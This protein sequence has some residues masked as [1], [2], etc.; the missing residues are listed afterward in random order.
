[1]KEE[2]NE[3]YI[4]L[5]LHMRAMAI[6]NSKQTKWCYTSAGLSSSSCFM[7]SLFF[8]LHFIG[9]G[10]SRMGIPWQILTFL[11]DYHISFRFMNVEIEKTHNSTELIALPV[12]NH[13]LNK[14]V[15]S[16]E[17]NKSSISYLNE[18]IENIFHTKLKF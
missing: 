2:K 9:N 17:P 15:S 5:I 6:H 3:T 13:D 16:S 8:R 4:I 14:V 7:Q 10:L 11:F 1:M 18:F 12:V